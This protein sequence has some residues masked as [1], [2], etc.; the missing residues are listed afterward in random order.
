VRVRDLYHRLGEPETWET[1]IAG[2]RARNRHL[3]AFKD[4]LNKAGL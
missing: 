4:E 3:T 1:L 2:L